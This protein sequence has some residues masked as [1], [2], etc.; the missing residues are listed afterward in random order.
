MLGVKVIGGADMHDIRSLLTQHQRDIIIGLA[1][2]K[3]CC[4]F[5]RAARHAYNLATQLPNQSGMDARYSACPDDR[6]THRPSLLSRV[7]N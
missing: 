1:H 5:D 6:G 2:A 4:R 3:G 7:S